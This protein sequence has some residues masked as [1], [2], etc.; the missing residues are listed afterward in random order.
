MLVLQIEAPPTCGRS[1]RFFHTSHENRLISHPRPV[2]PGREG[3]GRWHDEKEKWYVVDAT[4]GRNIVKILT[5]HTPSGE[6]VD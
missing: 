2:S 4:L 6:A 5:V 3:E 1:S